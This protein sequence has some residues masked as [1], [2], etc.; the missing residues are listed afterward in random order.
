MQIKG[1]FFFQCMADAENGHAD[2][3]EKREGANWEIRVAVQTVRV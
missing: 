2:M 1:D 3:G